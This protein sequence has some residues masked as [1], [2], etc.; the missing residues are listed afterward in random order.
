MSIHSWNGA[1]ATDY[2]LVLVRPPFVRF[3]VPPM[4]VFTNEVASLPKVMLFLTTTPSLEPALAPAND[5]EPRS[6]ARKAF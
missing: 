4:L 3:V 5:I 1:V 2:G 6:P